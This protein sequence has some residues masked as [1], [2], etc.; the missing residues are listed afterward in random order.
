MGTFI[1]LDNFEIQFF[2]PSQH[3]YF[4][5]FGCI[6][7]M[8]MLCSMCSMNEYK[9]QF[10]L[11]LL[12]YLMLHSSSNS[13]IIYSILYLILTSDL[14]TE[15]QS[16]YRDQS[17]ARMQSNRDI[18]ASFS[19]LYLVKITLFCDDRQKTECTQMSSEINK[20]RLFRLF[21][22]NAALT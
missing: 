17:V 6:I 2:I 11:S 19:M 1:L 4:F 18:I 15:N 10:F 3:F 16:S 7:S 9:I 20:S 13:L 8:P 21:A 5:L 14:N 22:G 12:A